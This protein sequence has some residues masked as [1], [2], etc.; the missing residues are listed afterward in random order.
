MF[1]LRYSLE[2]FKSL[3]EVKRRR[4]KSISKEVQVLPKIRTLIPFS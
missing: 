2:D 4:K 3:W 1:Q